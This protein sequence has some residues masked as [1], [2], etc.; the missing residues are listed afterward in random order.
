M[1]SNTKTKKSLEEIRNEE[2]V[3]KYVISSY[4]ACYNH[5]RLRW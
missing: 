2:K 4:D 3:F 5:G 1:K